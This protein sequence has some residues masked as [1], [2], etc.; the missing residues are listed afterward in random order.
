MSTALLNKQ[1]TV[2][3]EEEDM[4]PA[5]GQAALVDNGTQFPGN[6][7]IVLRHDVEKLIW[8]TLSLTVFSLSPKLALHR[9]SRAARSLRR[10]FYV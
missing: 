8:H 3:G 10:S 6:D 2:R 1:L 7:R 9:S 4:D 5:M